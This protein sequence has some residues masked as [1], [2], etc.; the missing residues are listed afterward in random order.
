MA[1][2]EIAEAS[3][4]VD[5]LDRS[6]RTSENTSKDAVIG[7]DRKDHQKIHQEASEAGKTFGTFSDN[8]NDQSF[9]SVKPGETKEQYQSRL[10]QRKL[11]VEPL[12]LFDSRTGEVHYDARKRHQAVQNLEPTKTANQENMTTAETKA[13]GG[14]NAQMMFDAI[15]KMPDGPAKT[16]AWE[17]IKATYSDLA[18]ESGAEERSGIAEGSNESKSYSLEHSPDGKTII[19]SGVSE[20]NLGQ[21]YSKLPPDYQ[22]KVIEAL[23]KGSEVGQ[24]SIS[25]TADDILKQATEGYVDAAK[26]PFDLLEMGGKGLLSILEFERDL[27]FNPEA[28]NQKASVAG[29]NIGYALVA[30]VKLFT[31]LSTYASDIQQSGDHTRPFQ[32]LGNALGHWYD[33]L[34]PGDQMH[35]MA[36]I[37]AGFGI[38]AAAG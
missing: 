28:A 33:G 2:R 3:E 31:G 30:G 10:E 37:S 4:K 32:D 11:K 15:S 16:Q 35:I 38:G 7:G 22:R 20:Y 36:S 14:D 26:A 34:T 9:Q 17:S 21:V 25:Q 18:N 23:Q 5:K 24:D 13:F 27:I 29:E 8:D 12:Q 6:D 1:E 19:R